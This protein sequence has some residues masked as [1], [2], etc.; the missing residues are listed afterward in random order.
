MPLDPVVE[1]VSGLSE[2]LQSEYAKGDDGRFYLQ[3]NSAEGFEL[4]NTGNLKKSLEAERSERSKASK[5]L[6]EF[7]SKFDGIDP[8]QAR[9][10]LE[11]IEQLGE[12]TDVESRVNTLLEQKQQ[13]LQKKYEAENQKI[14]QDLE[15]KAG[16]VDEQNKSLKS[17]LEKTMIR[18]EAMN[19][20]SAEGGS[21]PLLMPVIQGM[22][23]MKQDDDGTYRVAII[24][25]ETGNERLSTKTGS[26]E[27]MSIRELVKEMKSNEDYGRAFEGTNASGS[28]SSG[29]SSA[30]GGGSDFGGQIVLTEQQARD[31]Q[32]YR[33]ARERAQKEGKRLIVRR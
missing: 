24:D 10:A 30:S 26:S 17:Q 15:K 21:V 22:T 28:G 29:S 32:A 7:Q 2:N 20:I 18:N 6:K 8:D 12:D 4:A 19:A 25:P 31:P 16:Q 27:L 3:V 14:R 1:D 23:Q 13:Q 9:T 33:A 11:K 5:T